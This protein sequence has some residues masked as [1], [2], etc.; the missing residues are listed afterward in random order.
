MEMTED[1]EMIHAIQ[2]DAIYYVLERTA[3]ARSNVERVAKFAL[4]STK[5]KGQ[6]TGSNKVACDVAAD[7]IGNMQITAARAAQRPS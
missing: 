1:E 4:D 3:S 7:L 5:Y 2:M 6:T